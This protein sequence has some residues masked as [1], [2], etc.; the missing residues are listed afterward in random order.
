MLLVTVV[1]ALALFA[2]FWY[3]RKMNNSHEQEMQRIKNHYRGKA[4][5]WAQEIAE[6]RLAA[7][8]QRKSKGIRHVEGDPG[9]R[10]DLASTHDFDA[11]GDMKGF[12]HGMP[13]LTSYTSI[14]SRKASD[15]QR[16]LAQAEHE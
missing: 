12:S 2:V 1:A 6:V 4:E 11:P 5:K 9:I 16:E 7:G 13:E 3:F 8:N 14:G 15:V 10:T